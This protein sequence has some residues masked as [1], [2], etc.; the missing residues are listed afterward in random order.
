MGIL[1][2]SLPKANGTWFRRAVAQTWAVVVEEFVITDASSRF[3]DV[4]AYHYLNHPDSVKEFYFVIIID[5]ENPPWILTRYRYTGNPY[6][7]QFRLIGGWVPYFLPVPQQ[8]IL[9]R[10]RA[11]V[12]TFGF[13]YIFC[14]DN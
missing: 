7:N 14:K 6:R 9:E 12:R 3:L 4:A 10:N 1:L 11:I 5:I 2:E 8:E 13:W